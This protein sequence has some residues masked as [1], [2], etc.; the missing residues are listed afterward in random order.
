MKLLAAIVIF[1]SCCVSPVVSGSQLTKATD[2]IQA[3]E[4]LSSL[5]QADSDLL[6]GGDGVFVVSADEQSKLQSADLI[7]SVNDKPIYSV[8]DL[9]LKVALYENND[10]QFRI[11]LQRDDEVVNETMS[12]S[13]FSVLLSDMTPGEVSEIL[14]NYFDAA[15]LDENTG[16]KYALVDEYLKGRPNRTPNNTINQTK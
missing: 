14:A 9:Y 2:I 4:D 12:A 10:D 13:D 15:A 11:V 7:L 5:R 6:K 8:A 1:L 16:A 3:Y